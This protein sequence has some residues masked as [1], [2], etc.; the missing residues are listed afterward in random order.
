MTNGAARSRLLS[1]AFVMVF[2][3]TLLYFVSV[4]ATIPVL[5]RFVSGP[6]HGS[7]AEVGLVLGIFSATAVVLRPVAGRIGDRRGR[8][9]LIVTGA[10]LAAGAMTFYGRAGSVLPLVGL[11]L[12]NGAGEA[13]FFT[14]AATAV[15][16]IA[17]PQRRGEALSLF[18]VALY[19]GLALGPLVG[20]ALLAAS[21]FGVSF[22]V[23]AS[24]GAA[25]AAVGLGVRDTRRGGEAPQG[26][27]IHAAALL[28]GVVVATSIWGFAGFSSFVPLH[29]LAIGLTGSGLLFGL[30]SLIVVAVRTVGA[31]IPDVLGAR[32]TASISLAISG[33]ALFAMSAWTSGLGLYVTTALLGLGQSLAFPALMSLAVA[34]VPASDRGAAVGTFTAFVDVAFGAGPLS[35]GIVAELSG[36]RG[37]F[38]AS[39]LVSVL[40]LAILRTRV[41]APSREEQSRPAA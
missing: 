11:R 13:F 19:L 20:E 3:A 1:P 37:V 23:A 4:G 12:L 5:P 33:A 22:L 17:P 39:A 26:R 27:L 15:T 25:A 32:R 28:P 8:R 35:L 16:D 7:N 24:I 31:R 21:G 34:G 38:F 6:L 10:L 9:L 30:F 18:S 41:R 14:G 2:A 40:G 29:A 36:Y